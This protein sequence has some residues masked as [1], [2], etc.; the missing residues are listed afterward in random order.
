MLNKTTEEWKRKEEDYDNAINS[1]AY[2]PVWR[3]VCTNKGPKKLPPIPIETTS[4]SGL[5]VAPTWTHHTCYPPSSIIN[6]IK[7][8][9]G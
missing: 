3:A 2:W 5:P 7:S 1:G 6:L 9:S 8:I 4:F